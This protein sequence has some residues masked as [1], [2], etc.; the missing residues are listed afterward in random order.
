MTVFLI[1]TL[2]NYKNK[3]IWIQKIYNLWA[4]FDKTTEETIEGG[5]NFGF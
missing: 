2:K 4:D 5:R 1:T 3:Y